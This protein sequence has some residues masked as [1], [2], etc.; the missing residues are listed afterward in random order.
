MTAVKKDVTKLLKLCR[1]KSSGNLISQRC[2][3]IEHIECCLKT[4]KSPPDEIVLFL[5][6]SLNVN[7]VNMELARL[8]LDK[9]GTVKSKKEILIE[10]LR[11][12]KFIHVQK[13]KPQ[14]HK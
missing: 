9:K 8:G 13:Q 2:R 12:N 14:A 4:G 11:D 5:V 10:H 7:G 3:L 6:K 1:L